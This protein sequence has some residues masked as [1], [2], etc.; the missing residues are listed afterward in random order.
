MPP[1]V[2]RRWASARTP[3]T[4]APASA[5]QAGDRPSSEVTAKPTSVSASTTRTNTGS[6]HRRAERQLAGGP[7]PGRGGSTSATPTYSTAT[8]SSHGAR[9]HGAEVGER[10]P[11]GAER[12][13]VGQVGHRQQQRRRVG[14]VRGGVDVRPGRNA[15]VSRAVASTTG[16]SSTTVASRLRTAV[17]AAAITN[18]CPSSRRGLA[19]A[20]ARH[21]RSGRVEQA[22]VVAQ[23][24]QHQHR[25]EERDHRKHVAHLGSGLAERHRTDRDQDARRR[26]RRHRFGPPARPRRWRRPGQPPAATSE[27]TSASGSGPR[28][29]A[30]PH[31]R[32][33][34]GN[35]VPLGQPRQ[36]PHR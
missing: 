9:H 34:Q 21:R 10:Q 17:V 13:Q 32:Q 20:G 15:A 28:V 2:L 22:L 29:G 4:T 23:A 24:G 18:T 14:Q 27:M 26:Y 19:R 35:A 16:V 31:R 11:G 12:Q 5:A 3:S 8:A 7:R 36:H 33:V 25:G 6:S 1:D 30:L